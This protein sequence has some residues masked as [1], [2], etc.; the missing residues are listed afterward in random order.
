MSRLV[1]PTK[2]DDV[3]KCVKFDTNMFSVFPSPTPVNSDCLKSFPIG[4][5]G[6][7]RKQLYIIAPSMY[8]G[9]YPLPSTMMLQAYCKRYPSCVF[10]VNY[11]GEDLDMVVQVLRNYYQDMNWLIF[12]DM[13]FGN[14]PQT[15]VGKHYV[16]RGDK[17]GTPMTSRE[18]AYGGQ[19]GTRCDPIIEQIS[20]AVAKVSNYT[21]SPRTPFL[22][23]CGPN[24]RGLHSHKV[25]SMFILY[26]TVLNIRYGEIGDSPAEG[27]LLV[28]LT[29]NAGNFIDRRREMENQWVVIAPGF[30]CRT[31]ATDGPG[32]VDIVTK[33]SLTRGKYSSG[34]KWSYSPGCIEEQIQIWKSIA[35]LTNFGSVWEDLDVVLNSVA[36]I[37]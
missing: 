3:D 11:D 35:P 10:S 15:G 7:P 27:E 1:F 33:A 22:V 34:I 32:C 23:S 13:A 12:Q 30:V 5:Q 26:P 17:T 19:N 37:S 20:R 8:E 36:G 18:W 25:G 21:L 16:V 24:V 4:E 29:L 28:T 6:H 9:F 31:I 2:F 14:K